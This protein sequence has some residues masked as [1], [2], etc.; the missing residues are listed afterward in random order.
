MGDQEKIEL[1]LDWAN[2]HPK[3]DPTFVEELSHKISEY[4][5]L[6]ESQS[7]ALDNI[8]ERWHIQ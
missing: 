8:I 1:I 5:E 6:T 7:E 4:G 2:E 3:F